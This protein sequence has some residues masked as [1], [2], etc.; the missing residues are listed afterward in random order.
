M[1]KLNRT[2]E[3]QV[4]LVSNELVDLLANEVPNTV[5]FRIKC[6]IEIN[7]DRAEFFHP[8]SS[9]SV[10]TTIW[11]PFGAGSF[12][13]MGIHQTKKISAAIITAI[14]SSIQASLNWDHFR[15]R[16][17]AGKYTTII[18]GGRIRFS[19]RNQRMLNPEIITA[20]MIV[21]SQS[22]RW[23]IRCLRRWCQPSPR[24]I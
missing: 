6:F 4:E 14:A 23:S 11:L 2:F 24:T 12:R 19:I 10:I 21:V 17:N 7:E 16:R 9:S 1:T 20:K 22:M 3:R 18:I 8:S 13:P 15:M 5:R